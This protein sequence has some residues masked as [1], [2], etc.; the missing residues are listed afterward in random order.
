[1][2][3][4]FFFPRNDLEMAVALILDPGKIAGENLPQLFFFIKNMPFLRRIVAQ[5]GKDPH[6]LFGERFLL[7]DKTVLKMYLR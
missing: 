3:K 6:V 4:V 7:L 1:M 5:T 2:G